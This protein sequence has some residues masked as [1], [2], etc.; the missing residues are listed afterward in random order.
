MM[1][2]PLFVALCVKLDPDTHKGTFSFG[3]KT[4][5]DISGIRAVLTIGCKPILDTFKDT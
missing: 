1:F 5:C 4:G 2:I 3:L